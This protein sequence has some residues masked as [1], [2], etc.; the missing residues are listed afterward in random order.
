MIELR[1]LVH[2]Y[3]VWEA[4]NKK[5]KLNALDGI[6]LDIPSG[7]FVAILGPNGCGK[8]TLSKHLNGLLLPDE[9]YVWIDGNK[10]S[11]LAKL[12]AIRQAV[13]MVFQN[14]DNQI[15][16]SSVEEDVAF[17]PENHQVPTPKIRQLVEKS[18]RAVGLWPKRFVSPARLSGGEK[19][20][21]AIAGTIAT[22]SSC[23]VLDEPTAMLDPNARR[24]VLNLV[25]DLNRRAGITI[26]LITHHTDEVVDADQVI[27]MR[28][29]KM[30]RQGTPREI[31]ADLSLL[32]EVHMDVPQ[33]TALGEALRLSGLPIET[34]ILHA[35]ELEA[36]LRAL[37]P[38]SLGRVP[39]ASPT[40]E[41]LLPKAPIL[42]AKNISYTYNPGNA[43]ETKV[44][45]DVSF[46]V[47]PGECVGL[48]GVSGSGK[49]TLAKHLNG[50]LKT[51][52]GD[53]LFQ[54][55]SIYSKNYKLSGLRKEVGL[56]FQYP[57]HQL[58]GQTVLKD[59]CFGPLN[60]GMSREEA[61]AAAKTALAMVGVDEK[62]YYNNPI[63]TSGGQKRRIAIA[64][65]L[66]M[67]PKVL[68]LDEPAAGLDPASK[69]AMFDLIT[70]IKEETGT[71]IVLISHHMEDVA[72][73]ADRVYVLDHGRL[74]LTGT[75]RDVFTKVQELRKM[76]IG[77][78]EVTAF[79]ARLRE[80]GYP[81]PHP[82]VTVP[83]ARDML[84]GLW[85]EG[86]RHA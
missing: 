53:I 34:P 38:K 74:T 61:E 35:N 68:L 4:E 47:A 57:E 75:P 8:S 36:Q 73:Y 23:I 40:A 82:A 26:I 72:V 18:L 9:G 41:T 19:Q 2:Q 49:T 14:P 51:D 64:G 42:E 37:L 80:E 85:R 17:G 76:G 48:V 52:S 15:I 1:N 24:E 20:R 28:D 62:Y 65:V 30:L 6:S 43:H 5:T 66:A 69:L 7:Q 71:A 12:R 16:G 58:F 59:V 60:L 46:A 67:R 78:P 56:V 21:V 33:I 25:H 32:R 27:L 22:E 3:T 10:T 44:L 29:G 81:L 54:G 11:D 79:T 70:K 39:K 13:G 84:L 77:V 86:G 83:E 63:D 55:Q 31:F 45:H 50:L